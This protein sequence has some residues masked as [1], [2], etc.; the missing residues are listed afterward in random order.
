MRRRG[1]GRIVFVS[2]ELGLLV[3]VEMINYGVSKTAQIAVARG[4]AR[5]LSGGGVTVNSVLPGPTAT[6]GINQMLADDF[7]R[8]GKSAK[9]LEQEFF[10][11][12]RPTSLIQRFASTEEIANMIVYA[13]PRRPAPPQAQP[14]G[15]RVELSRGWANPPI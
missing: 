4:L 3:P 1:W 7:K 12:A 14:F 5:E 15:L 2:S 11:G 8:T 6:E 9:Q 13:A 10:V